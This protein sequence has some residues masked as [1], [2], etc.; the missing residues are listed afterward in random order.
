MFEGSKIVIQ[1]M[2]PACRQ[3]GASGGK[4]RNLLKIEN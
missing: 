3:A 2:I 4:I 1:R